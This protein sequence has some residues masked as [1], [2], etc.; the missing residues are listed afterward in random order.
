[1]KNKDFL[2]HQREASDLCCSLL[3]PKSSK[4][5]TRLLIKDISISISAAT[6]AEDKNGS[7]ANSIDL[8]MPKTKCVSVCV[9]LIRV[10]VLGGEP[11]KR[12]TRCLRYLHHADVVPHRPPSFVWA[13]AHHKGRPQTRCRGGV[14]SC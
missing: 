14:D 10:S 1:M 11:S 12:R 8:V 6:S 13:R 5:Q 7:Q 4:S 2:A 9:K 3:N